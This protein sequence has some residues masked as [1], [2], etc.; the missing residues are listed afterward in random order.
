MRYWDTSTLVKPY[1]K[2]PDSA[3]FENYIA[4]VAGPLTT[5]RIALYKAH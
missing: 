3:T 1:T 5:S 2:E 4:G